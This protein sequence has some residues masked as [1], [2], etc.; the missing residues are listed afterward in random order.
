MQVIWLIALGLLFDILIV[1]IVVIKLLIKS[2]IYKNMNIPEKIWKV[3]LGVIILLAIYLAVLSIKEFKSISY[4]GLDVQ[5][6]KTI[7]VDGTGS[8]YATPD[9][10]TVSFT[11]SENKKTVALAQAAA[12]TKNNAVAQALVAAGIDAKD[13]KTTS[14]SINPHYEYQSSV[15]PTRATSEVQVYCPPSKTVITGYDVNQSTEVT[16]RNLDKVGDIL[17]LVGSNDVGNISGPNLSVDN[18][19]KSQAA[20]R[21]SAIDQA[22][23][24]AVALAQK[25]GVS[26]GRVVNFTESSGS[27]NPRPMY[28]AMEAASSKVAASAPSISAG[29][30]KITS[31]VTIEYEIE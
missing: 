15:C 9:I 20:A 23:A 6:I 30:D 5:P 28:Y 24:K 19:E 4:V 17:A 14:Y 21:A 16:V 31:N 8:T 25:L 2:L 3:V 13:I 26:L 10:A 18:P 7:S 1:T 29:E 22:K 27:V 12:T 11:V